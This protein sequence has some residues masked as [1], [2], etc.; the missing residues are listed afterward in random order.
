MREVRTKVCIVCGSP[1]AMR[2]NETPGVFRKR[3]TCS[4][5]CGARHRW[6]RDS[7]VPRP[8]S[9]PVAPRIVKPAGAPPTPG[10]NLQYRERHIAR[11]QEVER[12]MRQ[13]AEARQ[14]LARQD[15]PQRDRISETA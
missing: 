13:K 4:R 9:V 10:L 1:F 5:S 3:L 14:A 7:G 12:R 11:R 2:A 8:P 6:G 15:R